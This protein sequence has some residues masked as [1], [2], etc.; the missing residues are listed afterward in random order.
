LLV[1]LLIAITALGATS[2]FAADVT[3]DVPAVPADADGGVVIQSE[4]SDY[5]YYVRDGIL[6][7]RLWSFTYQC[8]LGPE[9]KV[10]PV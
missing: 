8:W 4:E 9:I 2:A 10:G 6:Y 5:A 3:T 1:A 7:K